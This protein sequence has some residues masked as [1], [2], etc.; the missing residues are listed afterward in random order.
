MTLGVAF[1][2]APAVLPNF[3]IRANN[4]ETGCM[5]LCNAVSAYAAKKLCEALTFPHIKI[6]SHQ[7]AEIVSHVY[8]PEEAAWSLPD[9]VATMIRQFVRH[10][11]VIP[12]PVAPTPAIVVADAALYVPR[13]GKRAKKEPAP[14]YGDD[15]VSDM[16]SQ[17]VG[18]GKYD[19][20]KLVNLAKVN[21]I[22]DDKYLSLDA[23]RTKMVITNKLRGMARR[24]DKIEWGQ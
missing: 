10:R 22:W 19:R 24:G 16:L 13:R 7:F 1:P 15:G 6:Q 12:A 14:R 2:S 21:K 18:V 9:N 3:V 23:G 8:S 17:V 4:G 20:D 11:E 5:Y